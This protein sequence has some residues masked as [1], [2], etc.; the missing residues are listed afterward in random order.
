MP[1]VLLY[2]AQYRVMSLLSIAAM[3]PASLPGCH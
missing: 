3:L 2:A 1:I